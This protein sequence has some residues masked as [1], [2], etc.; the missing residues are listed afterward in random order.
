MGHSWGRPG[1]GAAFSGRWGGGWETVGGGSAW[2]GG[3]EG[4]CIS[5][6]LNSILPG[7][8]ALS[9]LGHNPEPR[10]QSHLLAAQLSAAL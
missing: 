7:L 3:W 4:A 10:V 5:L 1:N 9:G 2:P 6:L 8:T